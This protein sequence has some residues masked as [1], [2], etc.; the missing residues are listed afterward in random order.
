MLNLRTQKKWHTSGDAR[1][2]IIA[3]AASAD[4]VVFATTLNVCYV[5][6]LEGT[7][8]KQFRLINGMFRVLSCR[9]RTVVCGGRLIDAAHI[10]V[11]D[12]DSGV[13]KSFQISYNQSPFTQQLNR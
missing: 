11:W 10:Y 9:G 8:K 1:E 7:Q 5:S 2:K 6:D 4:L 13:G 12:F 3:V